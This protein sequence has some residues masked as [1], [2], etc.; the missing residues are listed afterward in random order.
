MQNLI[1]TSKLASNALLQ[2][3]STFLPK[4]SKSNC[5]IVKNKYLMATRSCFVPVSKIRDEVDI[6]ENNM[7]QNLGNSVP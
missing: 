4:V 5:F 6:K 7:Q 3:K 2:N 1:K